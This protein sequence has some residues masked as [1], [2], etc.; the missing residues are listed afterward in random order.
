MKLFAQQQE[1]ARKDVEWVFGVFQSWFVIIREPTHFWDVV[2]MKN[3]IY[4]CIIL[5]NMVVEDECDTYQ[6]NIDYD[7]V[8]N[9]TSTVEV[10]L[11]V[12]L[13]I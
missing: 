2:K 8:G 9:S 12:H 7:S 13:G 1:S 6:N 11:G 10:S 5:H 3:I 4:A